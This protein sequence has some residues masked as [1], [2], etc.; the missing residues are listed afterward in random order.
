MSVLVLL[1][2]GAAAGFI[3]TRIMDIQ[4]GLLPTIAI[5]VLGA[6]VGGFVIQFLLSMVGAVGGFVGAIFG[7]VLL[8]WIYQRYVSR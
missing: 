2:V 6:F 3:A 7:A 8:I 4:L 1:I 5:G